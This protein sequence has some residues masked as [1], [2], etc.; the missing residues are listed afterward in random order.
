MVEARCAIRHLI[1]LA[2]IHRVECLVTETNYK[3]TSSTDDCSCKGVAEL[4]KDLA[5]LK[6]N[7]HNE[8]ESMPKNCDRGLAV[9]YCHVAHW[10]VR[11]SSISH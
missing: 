6:E 2:V 7:H 4:K 1:N 10:T 3:E 11:L 9:S 5:E 8:M